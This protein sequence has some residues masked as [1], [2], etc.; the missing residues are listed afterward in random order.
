M[1]GSSAG[2]LDEAVDAVADD[3]DQLDVLAERRGVGHARPGIESR[4]W[5]S[6][7]GS[8]ATK[9]APNTAPCRLPSPPTTTISRNW[10]D[11]RTLKMSG[12]RI[13]DL[14]GEQRAGERP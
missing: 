4:A 13:A 9:I 11:S 10:I 8:S 6:A 14:V 1:P 5:R 3:G 2:L 12:A 7:R